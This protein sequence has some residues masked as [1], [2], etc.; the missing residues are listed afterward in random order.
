MPT[1]GRSLTD[2]QM[3]VL[4]GA[5]LRVGVVAAAAVVAVGGA[6]FLWANAH[7]TPHYSSF[8]GEPANLTTAASIVTAARSLDSRAIIQLGLLMLIAVPLARVALSAAAFFLQRD[9]LYFTITLAVLVLLL[10]SLLILG[11]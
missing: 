6:L 7:L 1:S 3:G 2:K 10:V 9:R 11:R 8:H 4:I 5:L